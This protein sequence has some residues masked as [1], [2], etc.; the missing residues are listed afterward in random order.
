MVTQRIWF[1]I[2][3]ELMMK[4]IDIAIIGEVMLEFAA[5]GEKNFIQGVSGDTYNTACTLQG[6]G[7]DVAYITSLGSGQSANIIRAEADKYKLSLVEP[8]IETMKSPGLYMITNDAEGERSF[9]YWRNDSA[10]RTMLSDKVVLGEL[11]PTIMTAR[12]CF[13]SGITLALMSIECQ[14]LLLEFL[15]QYRQQ[16]GKVIFDPN[17]RRALW[18]SQATAAE[19]IAKFKQQADIYLPGFEEEEL[20]YGMTTVEMAAEQLK[21]SGINEVVMKNGSETCYLIDINTIEQIKI[22]PAKTVLDTTGAGDTFNGGYISA[23]CLGISP[24]EAISFAA[25]AAAHILTM[26]GGVLTPSQLTEL[27]AVLCSNT[28]QID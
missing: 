7:L 3:E 8:S 20:L 16:G 11:L 6:L 12:Y 24:A 18:N 14:T 17:Y 21:H 1:V 26:R 15:I 27:K 19:A 22:I 4:M 28:K 23:R 9:D 13:F 5:T 2:F 10:A 25:S